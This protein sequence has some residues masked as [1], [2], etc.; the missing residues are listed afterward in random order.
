MNRLFS[1]RTGDE[2]EE[3]I[4]VGGQRLKVNRDLTP[5]LFILT[6]I[7]QKDN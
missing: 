6:T 3:L 7:S 2:L 5:T 1:S 4:T